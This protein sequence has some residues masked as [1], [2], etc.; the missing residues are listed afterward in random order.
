MGKK[1]VWWISWRRRSSERL[2]RIIPHDL[3][4]PRLGL[5][6][7]DGPAWGLCNATNLSTSLQKFEQA[8]GVQWKK[9]GSN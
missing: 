8:S 1:P 2:A 4:K 9:L 5:L 7:S 3:G 6:D